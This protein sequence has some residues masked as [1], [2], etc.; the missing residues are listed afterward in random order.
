MRSARAAASAR[1]LLAAGDSDGLSYNRQIKTEIPVELSEQI[2]VGEIPVTLKQKFRLL[3]QTAFTAKNGNLSAS[4][5]WK[6][7][8]SLGFNGQT[9]L[10]P[11][12][13]EEVSILESLRGV[14]VGV[15]GIVVAAEFRFGATIGLPVA[16]AGPWGSLTMSL[17]LTNGSSLGIV[18]C[19]QGRLWAR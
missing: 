3:V 19:K 10:T 7:D 5:L 6:L 11:E 18:Q 8:G 2:W 4:G 9:L 13:T 17:G 1:V 15:N 14:S 16:G 12:M